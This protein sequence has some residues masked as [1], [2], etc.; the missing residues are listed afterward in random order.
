MSAT[1]Q[2]ET[3]AA[4]PPAC[5]AA[6]KWAALVNDKIVS[7]PRQ[8]MAATVIRHQAGIPADHA[9]V[10]DH[11]SPD[12]PI[13]EDNAKLDLAHGNVFYSVPGCEAKSRP[14]C[15]SEPKRAYFVDDRWELAGPATQTGRSIRDLFSLSGDVEL[16]R[17]LESPTDTPVGLD[18]PAI[19]GDGPVFIT[20]VVCNTYEIIVNSRPKT[21]PER[22]VTFEQV[23]QLA[24]PG[25]HGPQIEFSMTYRHAASAPHAG[26]LAAGGKIE[27][28][29]KGT[30]FNVTRTDKS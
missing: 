6:P 19:F 4:S 10:R 29:H 15:A 23:V 9:L 21:V 25:Q 8:H 5:Q 17:D 13:I 20:R 18:D 30:V 11:N 28:K 1:T 27:V 2:P 22:F 7:M 26:E 3:P 24:F 12:D 16:L 14:R